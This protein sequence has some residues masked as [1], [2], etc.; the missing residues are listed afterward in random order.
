MVQ[1][2]LLGI[3][4]EREMMPPL[5]EEVIAL[6]GGCDPAVAANAQRIIAELQREETKFGSTLEAGVVHASL[7]YCITVE[8]LYKSLR[9]NKH[10]CA[11]NP[12]A[13]RHAPA[14][15]WSSVRY[16]ECSETGLSA[17]A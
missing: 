10:C 14:P 9:P 1:G 8:L 16:L 12:A 2:R 3:E 17:V 7:L 6:S 5:A 15:D 4:K 11:A 13:N